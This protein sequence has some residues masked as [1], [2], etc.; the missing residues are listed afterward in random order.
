AGLA[1]F[2]IANAL[3]ASLAAFVQGIEIEHIRAALQ[4][5]KA[6]VEQTPGRMNLFN[7]GHFHVLIDYA[8]N[9]AGYE[10]VGGFI[11]NWPGPAI[12]VVGGPGDRR[13]EDLIGLGQLAA[14]FFDQ[15]IVKEDDDRRGRPSGSAAALIVQGIS[16][17]E[18]EANTTV[19]HSVCLN[20]TE[21]ITGALDH[22]PEKALVVI[23]PEHVS[24]TIA[25]IESRNPIADELEEASPSDRASNPAL[26]P[27]AA[28]NNGSLD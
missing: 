21:A 6:S 2:M 7:L 19:E 26:N 24:R 27:V 4:S 14:T 18:T 17:G 22:A 8:H 5:F 13:D 20:E 28:G 15:I 16:Q 9:P 3:A 25:L 23:F 11:K 1:P 10:A 12:G